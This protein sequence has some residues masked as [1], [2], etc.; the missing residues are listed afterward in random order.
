MS[1][2]LVD[3]QNRDHAFCVNW[4]GWRGIVEA[5][6]RLEVVDEQTIDGLHEPFTGSGLNAAQ[7]ETVADAIEERLLPLLDEDDYLLVDGT[8]TRTL[9]L[10][11]SQWI[12]IARQYRVDVASYY[13]S[14]ASLRKF[15]AYCRSCSGFWLG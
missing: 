6:R 13:T 11:E 3:L 8:I 1:V 12:I 10:K 9:P 7:A 4:Y 14:A 15:V 2:I 5:V